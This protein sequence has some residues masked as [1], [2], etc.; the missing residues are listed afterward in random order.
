MCNRRANLRERTPAYSSGQYSQPWRNT[1]C[2]SSEDS[3]SDRQERARPLQ[4]IADTLNCGSLSSCAP[5]GLWSHC[6]HI[7]AYSIHS[8]KFSRPHPRHEGLLSCLYKLDQEN[9]KQFLKFLLN[10]N[11]DHLFSHS[12]RGSMK[13]KNP[14]VLK[15]WL[16][17]SPHKKLN[18]ETVCDW[19]YTR[20]QD[21]QHLPEDPD[22]PFISCLHCKAGHL[23]SQLNA[24]FLK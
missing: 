3:M 22:L 2:R 12:G 24:W 21:T 20:K 14:R 17:P 1:Y 8:K 9:R 10:S 16:C 6:Q 13:N 4:Q 18:E 15:A 23:K 7:F 5:L 11:F 19:V